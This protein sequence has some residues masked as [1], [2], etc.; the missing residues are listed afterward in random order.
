MV[1]VKTA[2]EEKL[3]LENRQFTIRDLSA[4]QALS[5]GS[6]QTS[7][8][9]ELE[10]AYYKVCDTLGTKMAGKRLGKSTFSDCSFTSSTA[11]K[12]RKLFLLFTVTMR[13]GCKISLL[14]QN[15]MECS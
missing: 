12:E 15:N 2:R 14:K 5:I 1:A 3:I 9:E 11:K 7:F 4:A 6:V 10:Y 13:L 8:H